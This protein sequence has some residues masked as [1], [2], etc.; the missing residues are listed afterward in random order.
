MDWSSAWNL[1]TG[2]I[3]GIFGRN[4]AK[5]QMQRQKE[6][7]EYQQSNAHQLEVQDLKKAGL[8]P[9]LSAG[10]G[11]NMA[12]VPSVSSG[13]DV[14]APIL[15]AISNFV[16]AQ[17]QNKTNL[18]IAK[19]NADT[20]KYTADSQADTAN[21]DRE[22]NKTK[23]DSDI[24]LNNANIDYIDFKKGVEKTQADDQHKLNEAQIADIWNNIETRTALISAQ[25]DNINSGTGVNMATIN[26]I[27]SE[28]AKLL[29]DIRFAEET[30]GSEIAKIKKQNQLLEKLAQGDI[31]AINADKASWNVLTGRAG[32]EGMTQEEY[33][34]LS[35]ADRIKW[36]GK[37]AAAV[38]DATLSIATKGK[39]VGK[40]SGAVLRA[41][42]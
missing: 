39:A 3:G 22:L 28:N 8:N 18:E 4:S 32:N 7:W 37:A 20:A 9:I 21:K 31:N 5:K 30:Q 6:L 14:M 10:G 12:S 2:I 35:P 41:D 40:I 25:I 36:L 11:S 24:K 16:I 26:K 15:G 19:I 13:A 17:N 34:A 33:E 1:G 29:L 38:T 42:L 23:I 27:N